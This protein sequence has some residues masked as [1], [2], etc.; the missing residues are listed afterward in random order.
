MDAREMLRNAQKILLDG[1]YHESINAFTESIEAGGNTKIAFLSRGVAYLKDE[2]FDKAI[3]DF[4]IVLAMNSTNIRAHFY[5]G[6]AY[7]AKNEFEIAIKDFNRTIELKPSYWAAYF[8]RGSAYAQIGNEYEAAKNIKTAIIFSQTNMQGCADAIGI[9]RPQFDK[10][11]AIMA[12]MDK[13]PSILLTE[14]EICTVRKWLDEKN[15]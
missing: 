14:E 12:D 15:Q 7:M 5:R 10:A 3:E 6:I 4:G 11:L 1:K 2:Q 9:F 13:A 8:A